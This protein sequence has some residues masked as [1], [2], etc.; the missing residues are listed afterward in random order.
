MR[1]RLG[2]RNV[3]CGPGIVSEIIKKT[4]FDESLILKPF[5]MSKL[6]KMVS[7]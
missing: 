5:A 3:A 1:L 6:I 7:H 4:R 2:N